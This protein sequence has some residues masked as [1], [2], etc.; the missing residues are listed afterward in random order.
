[1]LLAYCAGDARTDGQCLN[2]LRIVH[3]DQGEMVTK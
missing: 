1:M 3:I 2:R